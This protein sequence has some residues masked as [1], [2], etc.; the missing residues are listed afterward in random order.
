MAAYRDG[1][2]GITALARLQDRTVPE[3]ELALTEAGVTVKRVIRRADVAA[4][5]AQAPGLTAI[6]DGAGS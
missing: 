4:L 5:V 1:R 2:L 6:E 3:L